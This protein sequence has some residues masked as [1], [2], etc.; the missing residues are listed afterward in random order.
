MFKKVFT[1]WQDA[2]Q[3][4]VTRVLEEKVLTVLSDALAPPRSKDADIHAQ[5]VAALEAYLKMLLDTHTQLMAF[6]GE[7]DTI[8][9]IKVRDSHSRMNIIGIR[10]SACISGC[11]SDCVHVVS[12]IR[13][14]IRTRS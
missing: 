14:S 9:P 2:F 11:I 1:N 8:L 3:T 4:F 6:S 7:L 10:A 12:V 13:S 5:T